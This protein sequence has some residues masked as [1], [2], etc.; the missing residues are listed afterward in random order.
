M[1]LAAMHARRAFSC[2]AVRRAGFPPQGLEGRDSA[3]PALGQIARVSGSD[4]LQGDFKGR[5]RLYGLLSRSQEAAG[6]GRPECPP[7]SNCAGSRA[8]LAEKA[9]APRRRRSAG[10]AP[11][12]G[13]DEC[14]IKQTGGTGLATSLPAHADG[15]ALGRRCGKSRA[16]L[17]R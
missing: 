9:A 10:P 14:A 8:G 4:V 7:D 5:S 17:N 3:D 2:L 15:S 13:Q 12:A 16:A 1:V 11:Q 6:A